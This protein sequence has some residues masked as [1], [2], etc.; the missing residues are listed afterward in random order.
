MQWARRHAAASVPLYGRC[1]AHPG[2]S[3]PAEQ[4]YHFWLL[5][6]RVGKGGEQAWLLNGVGTYYCVLLAMARG[7]E[8]SIV[9]SFCLLAKYPR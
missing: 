6:C 3:A 9:G 2:S 4:S 7:L 1:N 5:P 8:S